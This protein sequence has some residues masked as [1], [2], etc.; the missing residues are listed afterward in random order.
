MIATPCPP[1]ASRASEKWKWP[2]GS[3]YHLEAP[4]EIIRND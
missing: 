4:I 2:G 1:A 3:L